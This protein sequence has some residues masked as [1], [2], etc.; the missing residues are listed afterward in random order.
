[1]CLLVRA[2]ADPHAFA[3]FYDAYSDRVL[4]FLARRVFDPEIAIDLL[5]ETFA[6]ALEQRMQFRGTSAPEEQAWLF[7]IARS[8][9]SRYWRSGRVE[10][11][12]LE[13]FQIE[14]P[15]MST[16]E[17]DRIEAL[18]D[19]GELAED[20]LAALGRLPED[21]RRAVELRIIDERPYPEVAA[22]L[23]VT[24]PTARARVSRGL[25]ALALSLPARESGLEDAA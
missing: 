11:A 9:L 6:K 7:T 5:S 4:R 20:L 12:T 13:R 3:E 15:A 25:R 24:E 8:E 10:R 21:Q 1:V 2:Q 14:L 22:T 19:L 18:T 16:L 17:H 23:G